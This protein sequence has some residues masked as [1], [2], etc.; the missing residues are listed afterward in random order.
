MRVGYNEVA[1][2]SNEGSRSVKRGIGKVNMVGSNHLGC[3]EPQNNRD[4]C[5]KA[6]FHKNSKRTQINADG[7]RLIFSAVIKSLALD[8]WPRTEIQQKP[9]FNLSCFEIVQELRFVFL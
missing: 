1:G 8:F 9:N 2:I 6:L 5:M 7:L 4:H 3:Y